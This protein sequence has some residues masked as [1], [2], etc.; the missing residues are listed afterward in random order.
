V[1]SHWLET[2]SDENVPAAVAE[3]P[4]H[5]LRRRQEGGRI[6]PLARVRWPAGKLGSPMTLARDEVAP[7]LATID[8]QR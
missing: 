4:L 6:E 2:G 3:T 5:H 8:G 1:T 7:I